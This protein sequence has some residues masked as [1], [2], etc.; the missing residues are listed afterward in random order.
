MLQDF[1]YECAEHG[2]QA[3]KS[4]FI[5]VTCRTII[6]LWVLSKILIGV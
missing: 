1:R 2:I 3:F 5:H 4:P 6:M